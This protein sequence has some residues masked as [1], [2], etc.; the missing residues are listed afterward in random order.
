MR[1]GD[2]GGSGGLSGLAVERAVRRAN[3][4]ILQAIDRGPAEEP[5]RPQFASSGA[6]VLYES[7]GAEGPEGSFIFLHGFGDTAAGWTELASLLIQ[8]LPG[9]RAVLPT[10]PLGRVPWMEGRDVRTWFEPRG[11]NFTGSQPPGR[12]TC[13]GH[14]YA[15]ESV[16]GLVAA[17]RRRGVP[18]ERIVL[19]GFSQ[20]GALALMAG[21]DLPEQPGG[22][23]AMSGYLPRVTKP[24]GGTTSILF[25][26]GTEDAVSPPEW[27]QTARVE[28][29]SSG[30]REVG[31][32]LFKGM[33]HEV[34]EE[35]VLVARSWLERRFQPRATEGAGGEV[36][37][38]EEC[39]RS[40]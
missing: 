35:E 27:A 9:V 6:H 15:L 8:D 34:C 25:L 4:R 28:L 33:G 22:I 23:L 11:R 5:R 38:R 16:E 12:W 18:L 17:E 26:H 10:A 30:M 21:L 1:L 19:G 31:M 29:L 2:R 37:E 39:Q 14:Q 32:H 13:E 24:R 20:G 7:A 40:P 3:R 36:G